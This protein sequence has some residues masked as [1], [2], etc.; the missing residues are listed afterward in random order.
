MPA[1]YKGKPPERKG[2]DCQSFLGNMNEKILNE[3]E[4]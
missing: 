1:E 2:Q 3:N 4:Q